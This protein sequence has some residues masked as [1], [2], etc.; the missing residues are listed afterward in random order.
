MLKKGDVVSDADDNDDMR[1]SASLNRVTAIMF[2]FWRLQTLE[3]IWFGKQKIHRR[4][5]D[6]H[7][8]AV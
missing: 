5:S 4:Y 7:P 1:T 2:M 8:P 6:P 3:I